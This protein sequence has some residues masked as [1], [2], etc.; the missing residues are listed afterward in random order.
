MTTPSQADIVNAVAASLVKKDMSKQAA[1]VLLKSTEK[2][3]NRI[4][5]GI[6]SQV[7]EDS[8]PIIEDFVKNVASKLS[9]STQQ[10]VD[11]SKNDLLVF[12]EGTKYTFRDGNI[13]TIIV[14]QPPQLRHINVGRDFVKS[15]EHYMLAMPYI[16]FIIS[17]NGDNLVQKLHVTCSKKSVTDL[18]TTMNH[19]PLWNIDNHAVCFGSNWPTHGNM[20]EKV[21]AVIG[22]FWQ[23]LFNANHTV[24]FDNFCNDNFR[25][26]QDGYQSWEN[27]SKRDA[28]F[29]VA[30]KTKL[31]VG[32]PLR[33]FLKKDANSVNGSAALV[34]KLKQEIITAVGT[35]GGDI[36]NMLSN[37]DLTT[38]NR[39]KTHVQN[40]QEIIKEIIVQ[41]YSELWI[42]VE[43]QLE[44]D[45]QKLQ[46][47]MQIAANKLKRD[48]DAY[49]KD[50]KTKTW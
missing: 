9:S 29:M 42:F 30:P 20:T 3:L 44:S 17:F 32:R 45:R 39:E 6:D 22:E 1:S 31:L 50:R 33:S 47:E 35:I 38:E 10:W 8:S 19:L 11:S 16:Q 21:N 18:D 13:S 40:L 15:A 24:A 34:T 5:Q 36:Q 49:M 37:L 27:E 14:E 4:K 12:P 43:K 25:G 46:N 26:H 28:L 23:G 2:V 7:K 48:F 41:A